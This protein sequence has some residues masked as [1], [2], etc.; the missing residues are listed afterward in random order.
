MKLTSWPK[1]F[2]GDAGRRQEC[3][4]RQRRVWRRQQQQQVQQ[5]QADGAASNEGEERDLPEQQIVRKP[6]SVQWH[7]AI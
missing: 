2:A 4:E 6:G 7:N 1:L 5:E 3:G